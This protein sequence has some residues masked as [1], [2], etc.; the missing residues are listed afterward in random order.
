[1]ASG[2]LSEELIRGKAPSFFQL[3]WADDPWG[4]DDPWEE[5]LKIGEKSAKEW[6]MG[7]CFRMAYLLALIIY[8]NWF[9]CKVV[10]KKNLFAYGNEGHNLF[11]QQIP[12]ANYISH[13]PNLKLIFTLDDTV[14]GYWW[15]VVGT[16][17]RRRGCQF[18]I[19][20]LPKTGTTGMIFMWQRTSK[21]GVF[22]KSRSLAQKR[23]VVRDIEFSQPLF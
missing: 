12:L 4:V 15:E 19:K 18:K 16:F 7:E 23:I 22:T 21:M 6:Q 5:N 10:I 20:N 9:Q 2:D 14:A 11:W 8:T 1:M 13:R 3:S 17:Q